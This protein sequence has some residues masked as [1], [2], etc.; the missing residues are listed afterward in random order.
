MNKKKGKM[1][2]LFVCACLAMTMFMAS[3]TVAVEACGCINVPDPTGVPETDWANIQDALDEMDPGDT[4]C[5]G[6]G[7]YKVHRPLQ[8]TG[9]DGAIVGEGMDKTIIEAVR[10][11]DG[12]EFVAA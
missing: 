2:S 10:D 12:M 8:K 3:F 9:F 7:R 11:S 6:K 5:L 4:I 1:L